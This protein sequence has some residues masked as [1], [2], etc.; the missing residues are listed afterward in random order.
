MTK[1]FKE[2][3][4]ELERDIESVANPRHIEIGINE[5]VSANSQLGGGSPA[6]D[7]EEII[8]ESKYGT[9]DDDE[10]IDNYNFND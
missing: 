4:E 2:L 1:T 10:D 9:I 3:Q 6:N 7:D 8:D 5:S